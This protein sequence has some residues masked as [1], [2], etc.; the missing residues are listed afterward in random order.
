MEI[1]RDQPTRQC[2][3]E[4]EVQSIGRFKSSNRAVAYYQNIMLSLCPTRARSALE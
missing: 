3:E 2:Q 1:R 4:A